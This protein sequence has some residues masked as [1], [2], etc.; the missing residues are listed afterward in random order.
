MARL[1]HLHLHVRSIDQARDF[2]NRY[3][4]LRDHV[5]H[6]DILFMRDADDGLDLAL[7]PATTRDEFPDWFHFGFRLQQPDAVAT[8][9][10]RLSADGI[11]VSE[12]T[13]LADFV[14]FR[15]HDPDG[16]QL[17]VYWE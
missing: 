2:Y 6:G 14:A 3:F 4:G 12:L 8:L 16:Y 15:C 17:E 9:H 5:W 11:E 10:A 7:A 13:Q 1:N